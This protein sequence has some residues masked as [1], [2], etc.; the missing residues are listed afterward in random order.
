[1]CNQ[2]NQKIRRLTQGQTKLPENVI[3]C[4]IYRV[5]EGIISFARKVTQALKNAIRL[6]VAYIK[7]KDE[8]ERLKKAALVIM[9]KKR[10]GEH[11]KYY[12]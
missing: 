12:C 4:A 6:K 5:V 8:D 11:E 3:V 10:R 9:G 2:C 1:M 7:V